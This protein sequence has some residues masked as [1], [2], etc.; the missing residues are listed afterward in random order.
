MWLY[1]LNWFILW[2]TAKKGKHEACSWTEPRSHRPDQPSL[3]KLP[4]PAPRWF[5]VSVVRVPAHSVLPPPALPFSG[6]LCALSFSSPP[7]CPGLIVSYELVSSW[8]HTLNLAEVMKWYSHFFDM[9]SCHLSPLM[10]NGDLLQLL[11][12]SFDNFKWCMKTA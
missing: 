2:L 9:Q 10:I 8:S 12:T 1:D 5:Y 3:L 11:G 4:G 6:D 7:P